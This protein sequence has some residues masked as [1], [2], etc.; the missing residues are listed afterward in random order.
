MFFVLSIELPAHR[1]DSIRVFWLVA[2][3]YLDQGEYF[4]L[5]HIG[6]FSQEKGIRRIL[7][8]NAAAVSGINEPVSGLN[9]SIFQVFLK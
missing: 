1:V 4:D 3:T 7:G 2:T 5:W 8:K 9:D 6:L